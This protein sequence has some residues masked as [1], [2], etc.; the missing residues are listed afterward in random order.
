MNEI[1]LGVQIPIFLIFI[2]NLYCNCDVLFVCPLGKE[3]MRGNNDNMY[4]QLGKTY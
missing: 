3:V 1:S 2:L 4:V